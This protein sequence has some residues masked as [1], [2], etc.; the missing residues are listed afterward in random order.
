MPPRLPH[1]LTLCLAAFAGQAAAAPAPAPT[2]APN[3]LR[4]DITLDTAARLIEA[5]MAA[6]HAEGRTLAAAVVD[7]SGNL[8]A[9]K[10]DDNVGPHNTIAAQ[11]KAYTALS[12]KTAT[13]ELAASARTNP[14]AHNLVTLP[15]LLLLGGGVPLKAGAD[16]VGAIGVAG[17]GGASMDES[18][19]LTGIAR[20]APLFS[21]KPE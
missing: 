7:R 18:C 8:V 19:A 1:L 11:R 12:T 4:A 6:C 17:A 21:T 20:L 14:E 10:R 15:E 13:R 5:T 9:L 3:A 2:P 16:V